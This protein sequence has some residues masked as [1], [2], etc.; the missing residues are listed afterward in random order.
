MKGAIDI[1]IEQKV[2]SLGAEAHAVE[3][4]ALLDDAIAQW[5]ASFG[6][7]F[8]LGVRYRVRCPNK[9]IAMGEEGEKRI[10]VLYTLKWVLRLCVNDRTPQLSAITPQ[11]IRGQ[12]WGLNRS[13]DQSDQ[14]N[15]ICDP[16]LK[17]PPD[18]ALKNFF[19]TLRQGGRYFWDR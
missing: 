18:L 2:L 7:P 8:N 11:L 19:V 15:Q 12:N 16:D 14:K 17:S 9:V 3:I 5:I 10:I 1:N 4:G 6:L 13:S